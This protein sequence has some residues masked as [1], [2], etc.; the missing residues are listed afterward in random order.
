M[1]RLAA[2]S[3]LLLCM[4]CGASRGEEDARRTLPRAV[5]GAKG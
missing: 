2:R 4:V 3:G 1:V 5:A